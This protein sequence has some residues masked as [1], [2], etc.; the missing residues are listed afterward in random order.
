[1]NIRGTLTLRFSH[2]EVNRMFPNIHN[3]CTLD[4][5][6]KKRNDLTSN[7]IVKHLTMEGHVAEKKEYVLN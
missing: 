7:I 3:I 2:Y 1:M 6:K 5:I 4:H